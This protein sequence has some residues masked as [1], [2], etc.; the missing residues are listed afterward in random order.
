MVQRML[1]KYATTDRDSIST[2]GIDHAMKSFQPIWNVQRLADQTHLAKI[3][4]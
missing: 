1:I 4:K 2:E 3:G